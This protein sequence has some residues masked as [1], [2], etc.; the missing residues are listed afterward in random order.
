[1]NSGAQGSYVNKI[2]DTAQDTVNIIAGNADVK[3]QSLGWVSG[4]EHDR[5]S[6]HFGL[7]HDG[8]QRVRQAASTNG[9]GAEQD[10]Y[11]AHFS[12]D[13]QKVQQAKDAVFNSGTSGAE[14]DRC[15]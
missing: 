15:T 10:R 6:S 9:I 7:G 2:K 8:L 4:A 5:Q 14:Q 3:S 11:A 13:T 12:L 1:M